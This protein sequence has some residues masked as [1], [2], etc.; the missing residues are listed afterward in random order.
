MKWWQWIMCKALH[1]HGPVEIEPRKATCVWCGKV[2]T[3]E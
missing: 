3:G 2:V 1:L